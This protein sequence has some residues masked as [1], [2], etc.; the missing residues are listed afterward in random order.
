MSETIKISCP[1]CGSTSS[2]KEGLS[3]FV[4]HYCGTQFRV[5]HK[6]G[7]IS[8]SPILE[9]MQ[10]LQT[11]MDRTAAELTVKRLKEEIFHL[12]NKI[13]PLMPEYNQLKLQASKTKFVFVFKKFWWLFL[14][15]TIIL[16]IIS[17]TQD[18]PALAGITVVALILFIAAGIGGMIALSKATKRLEQLSPT[19]EPLLE[20]LTEKEQRLESL[21]SY[22]NE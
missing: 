17:I 8:L 2:R 1:A 19:V 4:C 9:T 15:L 7:G 13:A 5:E 16:F 6:N 14:I 10:T 18:L 12:N 21:L 22:L 11:G 3:D 20:Q